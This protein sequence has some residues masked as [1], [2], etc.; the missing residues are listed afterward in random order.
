MIGRGINTIS[1]AGFEASHIAWISCQ[2]KSVVEI[3]LFMA[4]PALSLLLLLHDKKQL[5]S[6]PNLETPEVNFFDAFAAARRRILNGGSPL[7]RLDGSEQLLWP[8]DISF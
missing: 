6:C 3:R 5:P 1:L 8:R 4:L 2:F 7:K